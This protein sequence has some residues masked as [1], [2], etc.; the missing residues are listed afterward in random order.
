MYDELKDH[1][2]VVITVALD[3]SSEDAREFIEAARPTH[4][5]LIDTD[6]LVADLYRIVKSWGAN[7]PARTK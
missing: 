5:S 7:S 4:P 3:K 2:F 6:H 1:N